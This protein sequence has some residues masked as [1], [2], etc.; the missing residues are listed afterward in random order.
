M[1]TLIVHTATKEELK[2]VKGIMKALRVKYEE[3]PYKTEYVAKIEK[4]KADVQAGRTTKISLDEI[5]K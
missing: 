4:G 3:S 5:W 2:V 1:E